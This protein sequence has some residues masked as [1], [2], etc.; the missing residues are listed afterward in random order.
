M[1]GIT[2]RGDAA[3]DLSWIPWVKSGKPAIL[4]TK[5]PAKLLPHVTPQDNVIIHCTITGLGASLIEPNVPTWDSAIIAY[6]KLV[7]DFGPDRI[8]LRID[9]IL[10]PIKSVAIK[11]WQQKMGRVRISFL[12]GYQHVRTRWA[13]HPI[14]DN[15]LL[16]KDF[17]YPL[18]ERIACWNEMNQPEVCGE[19]GMKCTGCVSAKDLEVLGVRQV[20]GLGHQ[21]PACACLSLKHELLTSRQRCPHGCL[22]CYWKD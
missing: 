3:L 21:R 19:P 14:L 22:Y 9:P 15:N 10:I 1:I 5:D 20:T 11:V 17:H 8:V 7:K 16:P 6:H 13:K 12:D 18:A 4:I 2:E